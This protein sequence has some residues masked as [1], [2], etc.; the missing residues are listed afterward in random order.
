MG[1]GDRVILTAQSRAMM[2]Y[3]MDMEGVIVDVLEGES[4]PY[5][6]NFPEMGK[7]HKEFFDRYELINL[8]K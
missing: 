4:Y 8:K 3:K 1:I 6:V 2:G 5:V 7:D